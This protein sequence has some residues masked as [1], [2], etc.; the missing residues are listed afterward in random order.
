VL[1]RTLGRLTALPE[2]PPVIM[3]DMARP[4]AARRRPS[5][6]DGADLLDMPAGGLL[7]A[8]GVTGLAGCSC[9]IRPIPALL[10]SGS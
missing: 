1:L 10:S 3:V 6:Q 2:Q 9:P 4:A 5:L 7:G 8:V